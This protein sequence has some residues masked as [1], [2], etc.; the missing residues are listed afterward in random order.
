M[1]PLF[2]KA[3]RLSHEVIGAA[4]EVHRETGS[5]LLESIYERCLVHELSIRGISAVQQAPVV[6]EY[7]GLKFE[8]TLRLDLLVEGCLL[9]ELKSVQDVLPV[10]KAQLFSY[11][12]LLNVPL[13][14]LINF[15]EPK[16]TSGIHRMMLPG[17]SGK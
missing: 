11:M 15:H 4:I 8:E 14:L 5:G 10:H 3:D 1:H 12:K 2:L 9:V 16:L 13:G 17:S 7:K 6:I